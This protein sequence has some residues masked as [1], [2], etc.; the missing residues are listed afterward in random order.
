VWFLMSLGASAHEAADVAQT[1]FRAGPSSGLI[2]CRFRTIC[3][4][5]GTGISGWI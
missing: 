5:T 3:S 2:P 4:G 1:A